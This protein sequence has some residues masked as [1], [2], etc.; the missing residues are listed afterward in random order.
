MPV[1]DAGVLLNTRW[2]TDAST[3][4]GLITEALGHLPTPG[5]RVT[6]GDVEFEVESVRRRAVVS[7]VARDTRPVATDHDAQ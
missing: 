6:I 3:I 1:D 4:N 5:E 7:A 2:D